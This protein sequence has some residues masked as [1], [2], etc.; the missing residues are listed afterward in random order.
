MGYMEKDTLDI[1]D[2]TYKKDN[3]FV[4]VSHMPIYDIDSL[5]LTLTDDQKSRYHKY[6]GQLENILYD[7]RFDNSRTI[8]LFQ[9]AEGLNRILDKLYRNVNNV[10]ANLQF[11]GKQ[12]RVLS[13]VLRDIEKAEKY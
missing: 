10:E 8:N 4:T 9:I 7:V 13:D 11:V 3:E 6:R 1:K 5:L 2:K 12:L